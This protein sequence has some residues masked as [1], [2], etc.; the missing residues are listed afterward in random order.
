MSTLRIEFSN[1][2]I[3]E[4]PRHFFL[5]DVRMKFQQFIF[6]STFLLNFSFLFFPHVWNRVSLHNPGCPRI[7]RDSP[8]SAFQVLE[9]R[10]DTTPSMPLNCIIHYFLQRKQD[11]LL[12]V[13]KHSHL[14]VLYIGV[15]MCVWC[16]H[17]YLRV[18][19]LWKLDAGA[20]FLLQE[21]SILLSEGE[22]ILCGQRSLIRLV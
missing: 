5:G 22:V 6:P 11:L 17:M 10:Y 1:C 3:T 20:V 13:Q 8:A 16:R 18:Y 4:I 7:H 15:C 19:M 12:K 14:L 2:K 9:L 21:H